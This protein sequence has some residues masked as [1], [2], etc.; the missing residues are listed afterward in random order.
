M[1]EEGDGEGSPLNDDGSDEGL[2][3]SDTPSVEDRGMYGALN[4][5]QSGGRLIVPV[6]S[7]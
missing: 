5:I 7:D 6:D 3:K 4:E 1:D 2:K